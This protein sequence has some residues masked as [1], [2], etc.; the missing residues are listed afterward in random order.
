MGRPRHWRAAAPAGGWR[1]VFARLPGGAPRRDGDGDI[2]ANPTKAPTTTPATATSTVAHRQTSIRVGWLAGRGVA[3][4]T[5]GATAVGRAATAGTATTSVAARVTATGR[6]QQVK[7]AGTV[8]LL[9]TPAL[10]P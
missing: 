1:L 4:T 6:V 7:P 2:G 3:T 10:N 8:A 5:A 9:V